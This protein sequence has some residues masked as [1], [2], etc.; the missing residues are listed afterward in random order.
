MKLYEGM[1]LINPEL[2]EDSFNKEVETIKNEIVKEKG[3]IEEVKVIGRRKL[4]YQI[5][6]QSYALYVLMLFKVG[7][8]AIDKLRKKY[9]LNQNVLRELIFIKD[10]KLPLNEITE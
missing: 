8:A 7:T 2:D 9:H 10:K 5:K 3:N 6:K 4:T 1:F